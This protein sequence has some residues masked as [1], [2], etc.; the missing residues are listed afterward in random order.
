MWFLDRLEPGKAVYNMRAL[1]VRLRGALDLP[2]LRRALD[3]IVGRHEILRTTF[4]SVDGDPEQV[5]GRRAPA[6]FALI[7]LSDRPEARR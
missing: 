2:A 3:E 4:G 7:D 5:V 1:A 6:S